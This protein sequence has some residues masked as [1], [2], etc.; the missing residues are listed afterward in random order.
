VINEGE[1]ILL[2]LRGMA[3]E[4]LGSDVVVVDGGS[5]DGS[6]E[7]G[8]LRD[9]LGVTALLIK[10]GAGRLSAQLR[11]GL[12]WSLARG[13]RGVVTIDGNGKDDYRAIPRFVSALE[14][15]FDY[16]QGSRYLPGGI[17]EHTPWDRSLGVRLIH[18]PL[19]S[20]G[21]GRRY[22]DTTNGFRAFSSRFLLDHRVRPFRSVFDT[23]NLH[24][25]LAVRAARLDFR[26]REIPVTRRYPPKGRT[27]SKISGLSV[28]LHILKQAFVA[29]CGGYNPP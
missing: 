24:Y 1:R 9:E 2:Q 20:L 21:A 4:H 8:H 29:A 7:P 17:A 19:I 12:A 10:H 14:D 3:G 23:Y 5:T 13:Y 11:V 27:P 16:V 6:M 18:A 25:Y 15:G 22:T 28:R 26:V